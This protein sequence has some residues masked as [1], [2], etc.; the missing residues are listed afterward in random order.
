MGVTGPTG[1]TGSV[2]AIGSAGA[3]GPTGQQG[4][5][6]PTGSQGT[7]IAA[8]EYYKISSEPTGSIPLTNPT[9]VPIVIST[10]SF[11]VPSSGPSWASLNVHVSFIFNCEGDVTTQPIAFVF[12]TFALYM[13]ATRVSPSVTVDSQTFRQNQAYKTPPQEI[14][15]DLTQTVTVNVTGSFMDVIITPFTPG[16]TWNLELYCSSSYQ[17]T[18]GWTIVAAAPRRVTFTLVPSVAIV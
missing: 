1:A 12:L 18:P 3:T 8:S 10:G 9:I 13:K 16:E 2:G 6:G 7:V 14:P 4:V 11:T 17:V 5:T 15:T